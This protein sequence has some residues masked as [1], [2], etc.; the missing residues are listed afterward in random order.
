RSRSAHRQWYFP[1]VPRRITLGD[2]YHSL[3]IPVVGENV[4]MSCLQR[5]N[6]TTSPTFWLV[7]IV[8]S[9]QQRCQ[10]S[11][12][13]W[14][15]LFKLIK[16]GALQPV[17]AN[18]SVL[19]LTNASHDSRETLARWLEL[20]LFNLPQLRIVYEQQRFVYQGAALVDELSKFLANLPS[21]IACEIPKA[22]KDVASG[23][24]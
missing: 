23:R 18:C 4:L 11:R 21:P 3:D 9:S 1:D 20:D 22:S 6:R 17:P 7:L 8:S 2:W 5:D 13:E 12:S 16:G 14:L 15:N 24:L 10:E 19:D